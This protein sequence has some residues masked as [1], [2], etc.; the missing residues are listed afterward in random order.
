MRSILILSRGPPVATSCHLLSLDSG[1]H[2]ILHRP[3]QFEQHPQAGSRYKCSKME[4]GKIHVPPQDRTID[5]RPSGA[6]PNR[7]IPITPSHSRFV[8]HLVTVK[9]LHRRYVWLGILQLFFSHQ[10]LS[11]CSNSS[12]TPDRS[13][14]NQGGLHRGIRFRASRTTSPIT[15][16]LRSRGRTKH[17]APSSRSPLPT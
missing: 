10:P 8:H 16:L 4:L 2:N 14:R 6:G 3:N 5:I 13:S 15:T 11:P 17:G 12:S 9:E 1:R 7:M